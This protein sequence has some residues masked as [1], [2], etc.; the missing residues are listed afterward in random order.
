MSEHYSAN[1]DVQL[2]ENVK[3]ILQNLGDLMI[4]RFKDKPHL[5]NLDEVITEI[6]ANDN[7]S[8]GI[9]RDGLQQL[10]PHAGWVEDE[11]D[12]GTL[13]PGE[14][15]V[16]D[17]VEGNINHIHGMDD[18]G[19]TVTLVRD[20]QA[21]LT[22]VYLPISR[23]TYSAIKGRG[24]YQNTTRLSVSKKNKLNA[25]LVG[26]GQAR[27]DETLDTYRLISQSIFAMLQDA[28]VVRA[29]VPAT[30]Q[31]IHV[32]AGRTDAFWQHSQLRVGLLA[33]ALLVEEAGGIITDIHGIPWNLSSKDFLASAPDI[34][35][36]VVAT[37]SNSAKQ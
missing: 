16:V 12:G 28:L 35:A 13:P 36:A 33:G 24:A 20:N 7:A 3:A 19:I 15:W 26:T 1:D 14:W 6:H 17:P 11:N 25:A 32:A 5:T 27:H 22:A 31:L 10:R 21:V 4:S 18:W 2:L 23:N 9:L 8:L 30:L 29:S 37:L 34:H